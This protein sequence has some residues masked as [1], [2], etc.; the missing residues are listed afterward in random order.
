MGEPAQLHGK[1]AARRARE[2]MEAVTAYL[3]ALLEDLRP[4]PTPPSIPATPARDGRES[5]PPR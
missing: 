1:D 5:A 4:A 2:E 3:R